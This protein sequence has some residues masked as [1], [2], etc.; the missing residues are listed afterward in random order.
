[1]PVNMA[2]CLT[3]FVCVMDGCD[4]LYGSCSCLHQTLPL[5]RSTVA[6]RWNHGLFHIVINTPLQLGAQASFNSN[7]SLS[8]FR[9]RLLTAFADLMQG[10]EV[11]EYQPS[12]RWSQCTVVNCVEVVSVPRLTAEP[13]RMVGRRHRSLN[14]IRLTSLGVREQPAQGSEDYFS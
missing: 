6:S 4:A 8:S 5:Y 3:L 9:A 7:V 11:S 10:T 2:L 13:H 1:M 14:Q 12:S